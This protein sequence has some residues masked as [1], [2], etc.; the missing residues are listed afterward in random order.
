M[1]LGTGEYAMALEKPGQIPAI[2]AA[3]EGTYTEEDFGMFK[4]PLLDND[5][6][7]VHPV[8][9]SRLFIPVLSIR[10]KQNSTLSTLLL[11]TVYST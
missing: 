4:I 1:Y 10:K 6:L 5:I 3:S 9:P 2:A 8:G 11:L 7:N